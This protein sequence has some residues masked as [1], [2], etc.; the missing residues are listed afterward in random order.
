MEYIA[1]GR[2]AGARLVAGGV[3]V[4]DQGFFI[5]PTV[6]GEPLNDEM[7]IV[8]EEIF[9]PV[10]VVLRFESI[11]EVVR[12]AN[13]SNYGLGGGVFTSDM[14]KALL[15]AEALE[16]GTV[17]WVILSSGILIPISHLHFRIPWLRLFSSSN[18]F[19][20]SGLTVTTRHLQCSHLGGTSTR[21]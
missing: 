12:R 9:G 11:E 17:W 13:A 7:R 3:R 21:V 8:R 14:N 20:V 5:A 16:A 15:V 6:F 18:F 10:Q 19:R 1:S 4:G 2:E